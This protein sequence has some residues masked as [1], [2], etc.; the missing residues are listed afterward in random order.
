MTMGHL[1]RVFYPNVKKT[2]DGWEITILPLKE[3]L[4][5][6]LNEVN[7]YSLENLNHDLWILAG[8]SDFI[9]KR[10]NIK[11][12]EERSGFTPLIENQIPIIESH[13]HLLIIKYS[14]QD[15]IESA[16]ENPDLDKFVLDNNTQD[17]FKLINFISKKQPDSEWVKAVKKILSDNDY[18]R[19][20]L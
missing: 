15:R 11:I 7:L 18:G 3:P 12:T 20:C 2:E 16:K 13:A 10:Y 5:E 17:V 14:I 9:C 1:T 19:Y 6:S 8:A 4:K